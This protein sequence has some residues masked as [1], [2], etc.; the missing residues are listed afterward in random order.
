MGLA[1]ELSED[2]RDAL[3]ALRGQQC[4]IFTGLAGTGK[5]YASVRAPEYLGWTGAT[6]FAA[7]SNRAASILR[8]KA[9]A[10]G[11]DI[12]VSTAWR[13]LRGRPE[14]VDHCLACDRSREA[15]RGLCHREILGDLAERCL[16]GRL[17]V[18]SATP[19]DPAD[20]WQNVIVDEASMLTRRDFT[21][22]MERG[23]RLDHL[24]FVGD[25]GQLPPV[26]QNNRGW[27]VLRHVDLPRGELR[28]IK[29]QA[30]GSQIVTSAHAVRDAAPG[31]R[32]RNLIPALSGDT[33]LASTSQRDDADRWV[34]GAGEGA[35][36]LGRGA[37]L[38]SSNK[39]R[40]E[41]NA[42]ARAAL[43]GAAAAAPV[44]PG[45]IL[46]ARPVGT[47]EALTKDM[48]GQVERIVSQSAR[49]TVADIRTEEGVLLQARRI[50]HADLGRVDPTPAPDRWLYGYAMT[51]HAAQGSEFERV[52]YH[53]SPWDEADLAYTAFT[54]AAKQLVVVT[55]A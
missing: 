5:T 7:P 42:Y 50:S 29:R 11:L 26:D 18:D 46:R 52:A 41:R 30:A 3:E 40:V 22:L 17:N 54:R 15:N 39:A 47:S 24:L 49:Q 38:C 32:G 8:T 20:H 4:G 6:V 27:S 36:L 1:V 45:E 55:T 53:V 19:R 44:L 34:V 25:H 48:L 28:T 2:Q 33:Y 35:P 51:V 14:R 16:C 21:D 13:V 31:T 23:A 12:E 10:A 43:F 9:R 37:I